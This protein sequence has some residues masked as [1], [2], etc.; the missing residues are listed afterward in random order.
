M[1]QI[2]IMQ[3]R[4]VPPPE[5]RFQCFPRDDWQREFGLAERAG[6]QC[7]EWIYDLQG[8]DVNPLATDAGIQ[9][10]KRLSERHHVLVRSV[11][12]DYFMDRPLVR[13][14][15]PVRKELTDT[16]CWLLRRCHACGIKRAVLPFVDASRIET[17]ADWND[18]TTCLKQALPVMEETGVEIHLE[19]ALTPKEFAHLLEL[20]P[21]H[22][23]KVNYDSGNSASLGYSCRDEFAAYGSRIGSVH[24][25]DRV[26]GGGTV[27]LGTGSTDFPSFFQCLKQISYSGPLIL[28]VARGTP[29][30]EVVWA[31]QNRTFALKHLDKLI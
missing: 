28:Q 30:D 3:G 16:L 2:G 23:F 29:G 26:K 17:L 4:L 9:E 20:L 21:H 1:N 18:V 13:T 15:E 31:G 22:F 19:T 6:L 10:I 11:C 12:A 8:A 27:P 5:N 24:V 14:T 7:I 25:K